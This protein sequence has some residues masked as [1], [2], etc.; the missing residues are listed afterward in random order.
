MNGHPSIMRVVKAHALIAVSVLPHHARIEAG[1]STVSGT[2]WRDGIGVSPMKGTMHPGISTCHWNLR[3]PPVG[4]HLKSLWV[5]HLGREVD[6][7]VDTVGILVIKLPKETNIYRG[8]WDLSMDRQLPHWVS[9]TIVDFRRHYLQ[10]PPVG[11]H[12]K[13]PWVRH[14]GREVYVDVNTVGI[15]VIK[16]PK[17]NSSIRGKQ[18]MLMYRPWSH[19]VLKSIFDFR[20]Q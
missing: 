8:N 10:S 1:P 5:R 4:K 20:R 19:W 17:K 16:L 12:L 18:N 13:L 2:R 9:K 6:I 7:D 14:L 15:L 3:R 11:K